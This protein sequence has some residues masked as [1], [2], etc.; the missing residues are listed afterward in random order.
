MKRDIFWKGAAVVL[1]ILLALWIYGHRWT[2]TLAPGAGLTR[3][4]RFT[5]SIYY[6]Q[7][8]SWVTWNRL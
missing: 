3:I 8:G 2:Y 6:L 5:G 7:D 4:N 1:L